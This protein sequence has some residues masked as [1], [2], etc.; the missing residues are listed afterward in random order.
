MEARFRSDGTRIVEKQQELIHLELWQAAYLAACERD[1][2]A[3]GETSTFEAATEFADKAV[4][5]YFTQRDGD[6]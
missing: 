4:A 3:I 2:Y 6:K 1:A 5:Y